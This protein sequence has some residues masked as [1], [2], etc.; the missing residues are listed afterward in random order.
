[1]GKREVDGV[2]LCLAPPPGPSTFSGADLFDGNPDT[3]VLTGDDR[4]D[5]RTYLFPGRTIPA[6]SRFQS[7]LRLCILRG[8]LT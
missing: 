2:S 1:M 6:I 4:H 3:W 8:R 7:R 5:T